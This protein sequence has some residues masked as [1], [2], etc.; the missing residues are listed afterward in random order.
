MRKGLNGIS[1]FSPEYYYTTCSVH[2]SVRRL[3]DDITKHLQDGRRG[4]RLRDGV[5]VTIV[6]APNSGK[7]SLLN[8]LCECLLSRGVCEC[9]L[10]RGVCEYLLSRG[11]CVCFP[12]HVLMGRLRKWWIQYIV[13]DMRVCL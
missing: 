12:M 4:E 8:I 2:R 10:S 7:S 3:H 5:H 9:L 6:G 13:P 11:V 1:R